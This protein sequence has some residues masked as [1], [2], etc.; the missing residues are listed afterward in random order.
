MKPKMVNPQILKSQDPKL[1]SLTRVRLMSVVPH[2]GPQ[3][4]SIET[5]YQLSSAGVEMYNWVHIMVTDYLTQP[6]NVELNR[7]EYPT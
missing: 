7:R 6:L 2:P 5:E 3:S 1:L 4:P